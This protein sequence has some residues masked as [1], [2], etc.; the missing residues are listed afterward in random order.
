MRGEPGLVKSNGDMTVEDMVREERHT[1]GQAG[2]EGRK[3]AERIAK[4]AK[5]DNNLEY[6]DDNT[7]K[8]KETNSF[9]L[10]PHR[11]RDLFIV[12]SHAHDESTGNKCK[13]GKEG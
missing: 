12:R 6:I 10:L 3:F 13:S 9:H 8:L 4:D 11:I 5:F 7:A 2:G 1:K